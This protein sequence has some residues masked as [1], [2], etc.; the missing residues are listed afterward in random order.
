[1]TVLPVK[2]KKNLKPK[3]LANFIDFRNEN[4]ISLIDNLFSCSY[5]VLSQKKKQRKAHNGFFPK[6]GNEAV[7]TL[8]FIYL[9][10]FKYVCRKHF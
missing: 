1:M 8:D 9:D 3:K 5:F 10:V 2:L 6:K 4:Y 7:T